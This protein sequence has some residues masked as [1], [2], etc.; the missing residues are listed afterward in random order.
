MCKTKPGE[1]V[2]T[3]KYEEHVRKNDLSTIRYEYF[4]FHHACKGQ[5]FE[6]VNPLIKKLQQMNENFK[7][8][9]EDMRSKNALLVQ[10]GTSCLVFVY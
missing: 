5:K 9:A 1:Q 7:F 3:D 10:K 6:K 4:D 2:I 8:Y